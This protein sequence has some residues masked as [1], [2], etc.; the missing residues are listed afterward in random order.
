MVELELEKKIKIMRK[1]K[2]QNE[3]KIIVEKYRKVYKNNGW[4]PLSKL[5]GNLRWNELKS[6]AFNENYPKR[7]KWDIEKAKDTYKK[8]C[9]YFDK[10]EIIIKEYQKYRKK[11]GG[12]SVPS[13]T[14]HYCWVNF[15]KIVEG[16]N[17]LSFEEERRMKEFCSICADKENCSIELKNCKYWEERN[18]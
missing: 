9:K 15:K 5:L 7:I 14:C 16:K 10:N 18:K 2:N 12:I 13:I 8:A 1:F 4:P 11:F 3:G 6:I 17:P